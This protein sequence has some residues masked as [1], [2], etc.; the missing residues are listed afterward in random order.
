MRGV[1][2]SKLLDKAM[3]KDETS[4]PVGAPFLV[5][6]LTRMDK[7]IVKGISQDNVETP[8]LAQVEAFG[9]EE[10]RAGRNTDSNR[11]NFG[12]AV[13]HTALRIVEGAYAPDTG[14][15]T[16]TR[17]NKEQIVMR[18]FLR[19]DHLGTGKMG[20]RGPNGKDGDDGYNGRDGREGDTGCPG[21]PGPTGE[22]G[23]AGDHGEDGQPGINGP[24]GCE[25]AQGEEGPVGPVG[26]HG[27][28]G[29]RGLKG[30]SC[31]TDDSFDGTAGAVGAAFGEGVWIGDPNKAAMSVAIVGLPDDGIDSKVGTVI[32]LKPTP[33]PVKPPPLPT[34]PPPSG[35]PPSGGTTP[36]SGEPP[37]PPSPPPEPLGNGTLTLCTQMTYS[38]KDACDSNRN[39][40][41]SVE[42]YRGVRVHEAYAASAFIRPNNT[43][44]WKNSAVLCGTLTH[45][46]EYRVE[47]TVPGGL[48]AHFKV[49]CRSIIGTDN[50]GGTF[51]KTFVA[52]GSDEI[53][54]LLIPRAMKI[55]VWF[56]LRV[57]NKNGD[58]VYYTGKNRKQ[59]AGN[60]NEDAYESDDN[61]SSPTNKQT[62]G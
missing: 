51:H 60:H 26:R 58:L 53:S 13:D 19:I 52:R 30:P 18:D 5:N 62:I 12:E 14:T 9:E 10:L 42:I 7:V 45:N 49:G 25:G 47:F 50:V 55:P 59:H 44:W 33:P 54:V 56:T 2:T 43:A 40:W 35:E 27:Y 15:V 36:P 48:I 37:K 17:K 28:E 8:E 6:D 38:A 24:D 31:V 23:E 4:V 21:V 29:P 46:A 34:T 61:W 41:G 57:W 11:L 3:R 39:I 1:T 32:P 20:P 22:D 16:L